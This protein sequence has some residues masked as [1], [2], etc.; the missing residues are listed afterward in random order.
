MKRGLYVLCAVLLCLCPISVQAQDELILGG[1]SVG[2]EIDYDGVY[3]SG[4]YKVED[5][6]DPSRT[7]KPGDII[8]AVN[9]QKVDDLNSFYDV[10]K[11]FRSPQNQIP[12]T[13]KRN[14]KIQETTMQSV[15]DPNNHS[16]TCGLYLKENMTGIGTMTFYD[17][18][19]FRYGALGHAVEEV[20]QDIDGKLYDAQIVSYT[21][22]QPSNT[23][24]KKG[25][26]DYADEIATIDTNVPIGIY[27]EYD[28]I[29][30]N[31]ISLPWASAVQVEKGKAQIYTVL[32]GDDVHPYEIEI[33]ALHISTQDHMKGIEFKVTDRR[34]LNQTGGIIQG[35]S[36]SPIVQNGQIVGAVTHVVTDSPSNGYGVF[37]EYMLENTR[38]S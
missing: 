32:N 29:D 9:Y 24:E 14:G 6:F 2:I 22:S 36:G 21:K 17:P 37:I 1:N 27:G 11:E 38:S 33:T 15:Y 8:T 7:I 13:V 23:G 5:A 12:V 25:K 16:I 20:P 35:M 3:V 10:L 30:E 18:A 31:A 34:L 28:T 26:I 19:N 4:T